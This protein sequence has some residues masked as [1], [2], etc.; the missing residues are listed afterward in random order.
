MT[1]DDLLII[2]AYGLIVSLPMGF[3][4]LIGGLD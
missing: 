3:L 2:L 4:L 1:G